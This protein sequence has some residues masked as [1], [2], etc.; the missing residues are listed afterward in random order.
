MK[1][2]LLSVLLAVACGK[3]APPPATATPATDAVPG[4]AATAAAPLARDAGPSTA[5]DVGGDASVAGPSAT[6]A[7]EPPPP[8]DTCGPAAVELET[9]ARVA[10]RT[11]YEDAAKKKPGLAGSV[12][13]AV[14]VD[15]HGKIASAKSIEKSTLGDKVVD[16][17]AKAIK[18]TPFDGGQCASRTMQ[19]LHN[20]PH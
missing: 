12:R 11:C 6:Q 17:I 18:A 19:I 14:N 7:E 15:A 16:C 13:I 10:M 1:G 2:I 9:A 20:Y 4:A 8:K 5:A 3:S